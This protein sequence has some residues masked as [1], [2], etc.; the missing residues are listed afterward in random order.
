MTS[1]I[2]LIFMLLPLL[3]RPYLPPEA[4]APVWALGLVFSLVMLVLTWP[5]RRQPSVLMLVALWALGLYL[6]TDPWGTLAPD[7][8]AVRAFTAFIAG[9]IIGSRWQWLMSALFARRVKS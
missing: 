1:L 2:A 8:S 4:I 5:Q 6:M 9:L 3:A 7:P